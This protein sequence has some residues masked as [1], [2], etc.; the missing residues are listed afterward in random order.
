MDEATAKTDQIRNLNDRF[1]N[2]DVTIPGRM[3]MT[4]GV[5][6]L[7]DGDA[8]KTKTLIETVAGFDRF[9][10]DNDP[11]NEHDFGGFEFDTQKLFWKI[12]YFAPD[13]QHG[14][15][16]PSDITRTIRILTIMLAAEY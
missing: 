6:H 16:D 12:D 5:Q 14:S 10:A 8:L 13:M 4:S 7:I 1:R 11:H 3:M 9:D 2:G 15:D